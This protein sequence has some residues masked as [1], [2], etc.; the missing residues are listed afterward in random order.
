[1]I[2]L[3][4]LDGSPFM[5]NSELIETCEATPDTII[6]LV[7]GRVYIVTDTVDQVYER[8]VAHKRAIYAHLLGL[9]AVGGGEPCAGA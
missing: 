3:H 1:M 6:K 5:L 9:P 8:I 4:R 7:N 2:R